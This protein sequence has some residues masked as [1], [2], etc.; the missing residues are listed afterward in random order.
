MNAGTLLGVVFA[1]V[2]PVGFA[3]VHFVT[4]ADALFPYGAIVFGGGL[5]GFLFACGVATG[6]GIHVS[7]PEGVMGWGSDADRFIRWFSA[8]TGGLLA[9][10]LSIPIYD[11]YDVERRYRATMR[12]RAKARRDAGSGS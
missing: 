1:C 10:W 5:L 11:V 12:A 3:A 6:I 9:L 7:F 8:G 2:F 4:K